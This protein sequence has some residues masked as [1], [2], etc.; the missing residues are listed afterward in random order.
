MNSRVFDMSKPVVTGAGDPKLSILGVHF[1]NVARSEALE[2]LEALLNT[3]GGPHQVSFAYANCLNVAY[4]DPRY[5]EVLNRSK[6]LLADGTGLRIAGSILGHRIRENQCGTDVIPEFLG[7]IKEKGT[8][9]FLLG[10]R[11]KVVEL[12][13]ERMKREFP[14]VTVCGVH[15]GYLESDDAILEQI[16][17][18]R[19][20]ILLV[21][22]GV[23]RQELWI[24]ENLHRLNVKLCCGVGALFD[25]YSGSMPRA[26]RWILRLG[27]EWLFRLYCEPGRLWRRYLVGNFLFLFRV[28]RQLLTGRG[29]RG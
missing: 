12:A 24:A 29:T 17:A 18:A 16:N 14:L 6:L 20:D 22:M 9:V 26:P 13:S 27:A 15:Q 1:D 2:R 7:Y 21:G 5:R 28:Y 4:K 25:F 8:R 11:Q 19:P 3:D 10:S 23:P